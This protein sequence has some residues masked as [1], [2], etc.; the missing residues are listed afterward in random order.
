MKVALVAGSTGL[1]GNQLLELLLAD[2]YYDKVIAPTRKPLD[3]QHSKLINLVISLDKLTE[4]SSELKANDVYCCLGTTIKKARSKEAF[5]KV[6]LE[7]PLTFAQLA[8]ENGAENF[9]LVSALGANKDSSIFYNKVKGETEEAISAVGIKSVHILRPS[10]LIGPRK[11]HR[12]GE[13]AAKF[14]Y[15]YMDFLVPEKYK[16]IESIKV[17]RA[18]VAFAKREQPGT[19]IHESKDLQVF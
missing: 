13:D 19:F 14:V 7:Y 12:S 5:R 6:D 1:I 11:E 16:G 8:K 2:S 15:K 4:H 18:M 17:A 10:L 3:I 9:L